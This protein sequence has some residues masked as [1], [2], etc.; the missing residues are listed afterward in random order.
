MIPGLLPFVFA[1][2]IMK[3]RICLRP[4]LVA[5]SQLSIFSRLPDTAVS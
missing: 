1:M 3:V 4:S 2:V 5:R